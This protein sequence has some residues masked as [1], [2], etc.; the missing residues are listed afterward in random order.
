MKKLLA[1]LLS[2]LLILTL[3]AC[4]PNEKPDDSQKNPPAGNTGDGGSGSGS[5]GDGGTGNSGTGGGTGDGGSGGVTPDP[6]VKPSKDPAVPD[7]DWEL[8]E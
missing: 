1:L 6:I 7:I 8:P 3:V 4:T 5:T 2:L